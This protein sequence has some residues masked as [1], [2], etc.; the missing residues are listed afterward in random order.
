MARLTADLWYALRSAGRYRIITAAT[1]LTMALVIGAGTAVFSA[2]SKLTL[3]PLAYPQSQELVMLWDSN[4]K[5][6][7]EHFPVME[8]A[9]P[10]LLDE[11]RVFEGM[12]AFILPMPKD[13]L[14][15]DKLWGTE[16]LVSTTASTRQ[17]FSLLRVPP[18]LGRTFD[19]SEMVLNGHPRVVVLSYSF[20][21][22][23]YGGS[24]DVIGKTLD[25]NQFGLRVPYVIVGVMPEGFEF[26]YPLAPEKPD[27]W[28]DLPYLAAEFHVSNN[29]LVLA[30]LKKG[31]EIRQAQADVDTVAAHIRQQQA[32]YFDN[33][34][35][36]VVPLQSELVRSIRP[37]MWVM[38]GAASCL[39]LIGC[40]NTGNFFLARA[41][42]RQRELA[43][44]VALGAGRAALIRQ[45]L[46]ESLLVAGAGGVLGSLLAHWGH[47]ALPLIVP[48][49]MYVPRLDSVAQDPRLS[50]LTAAVLVVFAAAFNVLPSLRLCRPNV[51]E[52]LKP[53]GR[54]RAASPIRL[55][56]GSVL[57][58]LQ[59]GLAL[60]LLV[61]TTLLGESLEKLLKTNRGFQPESLLVV[62]VGFSNAAYTAVPH[63]QQVVPNLYHQFEE[64]IKSLPG[65]RFVAAV[66]A[67]PLEMGTQYRF[68]ADGT[69]PISANFEPAQWQLVTPSFFEIMNLKLLRGRWLA[70]TDTVNASP[71]AVINRSMAERYWPLTDPLG[72]KIRPMLRITAKDIGYTVVGV[73]QEQRRFGFGDEPVPTVYQAFDQ[74]TPGHFSVVIRTVGDP[75]AAAGIV[76]SAALQML[77]G[78][79]VVGKVRTGEDIVSASTARLR[80]TTALVSV[81]TFLALVLA[82]LGVYGLFS[83]YTSQRTHEIGIR[84]SLGARRFDVVLLVCEEGMALVSVG[85]LLGV[86]LSFGVGRILRSLL[87]E[88]PPIDFLALCLATLFFLVV[89]VVAI[90]VPARRASQVDPMVVLRYE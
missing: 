52:A 85:T 73:V 55:R 36:R 90:Y 67:F 62:D 6:G 84:M 19:P 74:V 13:W 53:A 23:H 37:I 38:L 57:L 64:R 48:S 47:R 28:V 80:A 66:R 24:R 56:R 75:H 87:Y 63:F 15:H 79:T 16:E 2:I 40:A 70:E 45:M 11:T 35:V 82:A 49:S 69:G 60:A 9:F 26:P 78:Q 22:R 29:F 43:I 81:F 44:R 20:W 86:G 42:S 46:T 27:L 30:R 77:P 39:L 4:R 76:R 58:I 14:Y 18:I 59:V 89:A 71:V 34:L 1:V 51:D 33:E 8:G 25:L 31:I 17:L 12:A 32:T 88:P 50:A 61:G 72:R 5:A 41:L 54:A 68:K 65:A 83:Y 10:I 3:T 21:L 7:K